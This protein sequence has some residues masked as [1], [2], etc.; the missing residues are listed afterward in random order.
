MQRI[1]IKKSFLFKVESFCRVKRFISESR[2][3][4][5]YVRKS[6]MMT[7]QVAMLKFL[8]KPLCSRWKS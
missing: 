4:L 2:N 8:Q 7:D 6:Q 3:S 1:F 5:K